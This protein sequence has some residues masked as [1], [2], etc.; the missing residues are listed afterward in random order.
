MDKFRTRNSIK[1]LAIIAMLIDHIGMFFLPI[2]TL[3]GL[4]CR[5]IGRLTAPIMCLFVAEGY[6]HTSSRKKYGTRLFV[7][8]L[9]SQ[10]PYA[11]AHYGTPST[12][13]LL[14][15]TA[16]AAKGFS[17]SRFFDAVLTP[18]FNMIM[19]L[20]LSFLILYVYDLVP[21]Y[22][23]RCFFIGLLLAASMLCDWGLVGPLYVLTFALFR[24]DKNKQARYYT[25]ITT[26]YIIMQ[27][28]FCIMNKQH[29]Y[30]Q[31]WQAGL[32]L[33]IPIL[34]LYNG[35]PGSRS[36]FHKWFF[37]ILYPAQFLMFWAILCWA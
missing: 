14:S 19:T 20:F 7:F 37:Y 35:E 32:Y 4:L 10:I 33:F 18:D 26:G 29:W 11:L 15:D 36:P 27:T 1:Y 30:G 3:P 12:D 2:T 6:V 22:N 21:G 9:I 13:P 23:K 24:D 17:W 5:V 34:Y 16:A 31:L 25:L 8:A 28:V